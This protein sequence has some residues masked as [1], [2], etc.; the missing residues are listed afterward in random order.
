MKRN[1][2]VAEVSRVLSLCA[3]LSLA[4]CK[5]DEEILLS[6][7]GTETT[8]VVEPVSS[9]GQETVRIQRSFRFFEATREVT[10]F[11]TVVNVREGTTQG[12]KPVRRRVW[13]FQV[14]NSPE[15]YRKNAAT[16]FM[17][18]PEGF[19]RAEQTTVT[20]AENELFV[21]HQYTRTDSGSHRTETLRL[22]INRVTGNF[23]SRIAE[24]ST[25]RPG[26]RDQILVTASG[27]CTR[28]QGRRI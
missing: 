17:N 9:R 25:Y 7:T 3:L 27:T 24:I 22:T 12:D 20:V 6:C 11:D 19:R 10:E 15:M 8:A 14:D 1:R 13:V 23:E 2:T 21:S 4:G 28:L 5:Q 18:A 16:E 26:V